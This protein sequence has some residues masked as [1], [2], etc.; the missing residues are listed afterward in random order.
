MHEFRC[1]GLTRLIMI[2][3]VGV[4]TLPLGAKTVYVK[5]G[6]SDGDGSRW[7]RA[8]TDLYSVLKGAVPGDEIRV[9]K[10]TYT[11]TRF[12]LDAFVARSDGSNR[13]WLN[14]GDGVFTDSTQ[15]LGESASQDVAVGDLDGDGDLDAFLANAGDAGLPNIVWLNDG[16]NIFTDSGQSLGNA[17]SYSVALGDLDGDGDLDAFVANIGTPH[18]AWFNNGNGVFTMSTEIP[19]DGVGFCTELGDLDGDGDLDV[20][21]G[22]YDERDQVWF[23]DGSGIFSSSGQTFTNISTYGMALGDLNGDGDL[24]VL[25]VGESAVAWINNGHGIFTEKDSG[26]SLGMA[27]SVA[28]GDIDLDGDLDAIVAGP[29]VVPLFNNGNA[30]FSVTGYIAPGSTSV[31]SVALADIDDDGDLD[32]FMAGS[33]PD[34]VWLNDGLAGFTDSGQT[35]GTYNSSAVV[36]AD[37]DGKPV[38]DRETSFQLTSGVEVYGGF[39]AGGGQWIERDPEAYP[40]VLSGDVNGNDGTGDYSDNCYHVLIGDDTDKTA[41]LDGFIITG[42][43]ADGSSSNRNGGGMINRGGKPTLI[44]CVFMDNQSIRGGGAIHCF[45]GGMTLTDCI[46]HD[47]E[48]SLW[49]GAIFLNGASAAITNCTFVRNTSP[50]GA[51]TCEND[52]T[53]LSVSLQNCILWDNS[54][55]IGFTTILTAPVVLFC[56]I[57]GGW[58]LA[59]GYNI[60]LD[61][62]FVDSANNNF[63]LSWDSPCIDAA[64]GDPLFL[65]L[66]QSLDLSADNRFVDILAIPDTG[67]GKFAYLDMGPYEFQPTGILGD[68]N[69]DGIVNMTDVALIA[70]SWLQQ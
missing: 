43:R 56:D 30:L 3:V 70:S 10:G 28:L 47:N 63:H 52:T 20:F 67:D 41:I 35:L 9:A 51:I 46:F 58:A 36:L 39:P 37:L 23:N 24:D 42:G 29:I 62:R 27:M 31:Y 68:L 40:T 21:I 33:G 26:V 45:G 4:W 69:Q 6:S 11:P 5:A 49:G 55:A 1:S 50:E 32:I 16:H 18:R 7:A 34:Q 12:V 48:A 61:P 57:Q 19:N 60:D 54:A 38:Q 17:L 66:D 59:P 25:T 64:D 14:D 53:T 22:F 65:S 8:R 13:V 2:W 44:N 15:R